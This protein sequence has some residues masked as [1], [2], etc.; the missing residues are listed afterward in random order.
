MKTFYLL[1]VLLTFQNG[2]CQEEPTEII[3]KYNYQQ[4]HE[5]LEINLIRKIDSTKVTIDSK[6]ILEYFYSKKQEREVTETVNKN[7]Y[8]SNK[9]FDSILKQVSSISKSELNKNTIVIDNGKI[10]SLKVKNLN[11]NLYYE[12]LALNMKNSQGELKKFL[13]VCIKIL[14]IGNLKPENYFN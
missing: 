5:N 13:D 7:F 9:T 4:A 1:I 6:K 10:T 3:F 8:I 11:T 12:V 2:F 14:D